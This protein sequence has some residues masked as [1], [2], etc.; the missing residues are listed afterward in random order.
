MAVE[1]VTFAEWFIDRFGPRVGRIDIALATNLV[2]L[3]RGSAWVYRFGE[4]VPALLAGLPLTL[5]LLWLW[6]RTLRASSR[7]RRTLQALPHDAAP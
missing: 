5:T 2:N 1:A 4:A 3:F 6:W 7:L